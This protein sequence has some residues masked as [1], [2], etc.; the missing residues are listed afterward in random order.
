MVNIYLVHHITFGKFIDTMY[1]DS[2]DAF[3]LNA[4]NDDHRA[5]GPEIKRHEN[6]EVD[7]KLKKIE[8]LFKTRDNKGYVV[9]FIRIRLVHNAPSQ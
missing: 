3:R 9:H 6:A 7:S 2:S 1:S 5:E 8:E 4:I